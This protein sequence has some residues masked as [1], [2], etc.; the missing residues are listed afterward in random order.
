MIRFLL[1]M[2]G[3]FGTLI[4]MPFFVVAA[5]FLGPQALIYAAVSF[6]AGLLALIWLATNKK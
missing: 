6:F 4:I 3:I 5:V 1:G 2:M